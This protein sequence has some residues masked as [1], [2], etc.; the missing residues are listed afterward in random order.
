MANYKD[1]SCFDGKHKGCGECID[2]LDPDDEITRVQEG[3][4]THQS[5]LMLL[6][7]YE[8]AMGELGKT[9]IPSDVKAVLDK[10]GGYIYELEE[11]GIIK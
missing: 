4:Q 8:A 7:L 9:W 10:V 6:E 3:S 5:L 2:Y 1:M 11:A